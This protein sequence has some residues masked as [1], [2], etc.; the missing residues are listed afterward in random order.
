MK[1]SV[2]IPTFN[3]ED[4]LQ[5]TLE[6]CTSQKSD[7]VEFVVCD[8]AST[9]NTEQMVKQFSV[10]DARV[11]Y[12]RQPENL[13]MLANFE[14]GLTHC[15]NEYIFALGADDA[16]M[17]NSIATILDILATTKC[18]LLTWPTAAFFYPGTRDSC[19]QL[20]IPIAKMDKQLTWIESKDFFDR[21]ARNLHYVA[22]E[23]CPMIYVKSIASRKIIDKV[24]ERSGGKFYSCSTPDGYSGIVLAGEVKKYLKY[25]FP[26]TMHG[27]SS[28][29]AG[30][31]YISR[32]SKSA[33]LSEKFFQNANKKPLHQELGSADYSPLISIMTADF[34]LTCLDLPG[35]AGQ[36]PKI[37][38]KNLIRKS[39]D[40][41]CDGLMDEKKAARELEIIEIIARH[42]GLY[43]YFKAQA[44]RKKRN[45]RRTLEGDAFSP[46]LL[47]LNSSDLGVENVY[48]ATHFVKNFIHARQR[49]TLSNFLVMVVNS[50]RYYILGKLRKDPLSV[51]LSYR[52]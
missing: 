50:L 40:E 1:I 23:D 20:V 5:Y 4:F 7:D 13:G 24:I 26:L 18:E 19:G 2:L 9:D 34:L 15:R 3:R 37:D 38:I 44:S 27:V 11:R 10:S 32:V 43:E 48:E 17:P 28:N 46:R 39:L 52:K 30:V 29:S 36:I 42:N 45:L 31:N 12:V 8:D 25:N 16:L 41:V 14:A 51:L 21:Q 47:Y 35:W 22:D 6:S 49:V 33:D